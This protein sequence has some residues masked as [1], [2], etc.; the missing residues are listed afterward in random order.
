MKDKNHNGLHGIPV[1]APDVVSG[2]Y[3]NFMRYEIQLLSAHWEESEIAI[4]N[5]WVDMKNHTVT[6]IEEYDDMHYSIYE[7]FRGV[8]GSTFCLD[9]I[10]KEFFPSL[11][12]RSNLVVLVSFMEAELHKLC[13]DLTAKF[14]MDETQNSFVEYKKENKRR[15][16]F[17]MMR[18]YLANRIGLSFDSFLIAKWN[19]LQTLYI[20]RNNILHNF[21]KLEKYPKKLEMFIQGHSEI[22]IAE[23]SNDIEI[24]RSFM[25]N[26]LQPILVD[27]CQRMEKSI[28]VRLNDN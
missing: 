5:A 23:H 12:R 11:I 2:W 20:L 19:D 8:D 25:E 13:Q 27:F 9:H 21:G 1:T 22:T 6:E 3:S 18:N 28:Q 15:S 24:G 14:L 10:Y 26:T 7:Y 16:K 4:S 17:L